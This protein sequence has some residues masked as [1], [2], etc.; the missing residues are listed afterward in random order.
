LPLQNAKVIPLI[1]VKFKNLS[2]NGY[3]EYLILEEHTEII[4]F[5]FLLLISYKNI[6]YN[7]KFIFLL[8]NKKNLYFNICLV[9]QKVL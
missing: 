3:G 9:R 8:F 1:N 7:N 5:N 4:F 6:N 2:Q